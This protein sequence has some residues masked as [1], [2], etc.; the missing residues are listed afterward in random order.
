[1]VYR[2]LLFQVLLDLGVPLNIVRAHVFRRSTF[3]QGTAEPQNRRP[4]EQNFSRPK[5]ADI[6]YST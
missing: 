4:A 6:P 1:M 5:I 3:D 2:L